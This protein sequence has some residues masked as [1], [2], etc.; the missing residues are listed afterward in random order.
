MA[1]GYFLESASRENLL[2]YCNYV[3]D[4]IKTSTNVLTY[5][6]WMHKI[7]IPRVLKK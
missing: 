2:R 7:E 4:C 6:N 1:Q 5:S 3:E